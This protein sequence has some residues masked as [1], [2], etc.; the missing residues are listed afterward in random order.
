[1]FPVFFQYSE[2]VRQ[3][4]YTVCSYN[5]ENVNATTFFFGRGRGVNVHCFGA[6]YTYLGEDHAGTLHDQHT[7]ISIGGRPICN[8]QFANDMDLMGCSN[9]TWNGSQ[10]RQE[11][12]H[13][14]QHEKY[15][16]RY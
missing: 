14:Q 3:C 1:M 16:C 8:L 13:D 11:Q 12:D 5:I 10:H 9:G 2:T 6:T 7:S 4:H 15:Q